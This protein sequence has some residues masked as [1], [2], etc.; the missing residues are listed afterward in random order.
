MGPEESV[1]QEKEGKVQG[2][3]DDHILKVKGDS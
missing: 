3:E 2:A 1:S